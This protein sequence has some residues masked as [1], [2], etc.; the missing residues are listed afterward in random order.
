MD[1]DP[2]LCKTETSSEILRRFSPQDDRSAKLVIL[3]LQR[4]ELEN[5]WN[6]VYPIGL[7]SVK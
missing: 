6:I 4:L 3:Y 7:E 1:G 5:K 2:G